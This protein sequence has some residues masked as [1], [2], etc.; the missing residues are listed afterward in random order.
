MVG[1]INMV[2][3]EFISLKH[4]PEIWIEIADKLHMKEHF[5]IP[6]SAYP[7]KLTFSI[8]HAA[9]DIL[10]EE[11]DELL[12]QLGFYYVVEVMHNQYDNIKVLPGKALS[13]I[14]E[15]LPTYHNRLGIIHPHFKLPTFLT[16]PLGTHGYE[17]WYKGEDIDDSNFTL[18]LLDGI[19]KL[20][21][22]GVKASLKQTK[23]RNSQEQ[24]NV[25]EIRW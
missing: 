18:G 5:V 2:F 21:S 23:K 25:Y 20:Y 8:A 10:N 1:N 17:I 11:V 12:Y 14:L 22:Y 24:F 4:S 3:Y 9:S 16:R 19:I 7:D 13:H 6:G 15:Y